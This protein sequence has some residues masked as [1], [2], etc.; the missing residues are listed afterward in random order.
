MLLFVCLYDLPY[1]IGWDPR[2]SSQKVPGSI[3]DCPLQ[4]RQTVPLGESF[5][6]KKEIKSRKKKQKI[7]KVIANLRMKN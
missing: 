6:P 4:W 2:M 5:R 7:K 1:Y 3:E